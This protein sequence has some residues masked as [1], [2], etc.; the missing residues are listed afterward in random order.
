MFVGDES[1]PSGLGSCGL[2][3]TCVVLEDGA[4]GEGCCPAWARCEGAV[5]EGSGAGLGR[6]TS[7]SA[8]VGASEVAGSWSATAS[9]FL[10]GPAG[11]SASAVSES[12][13]MDSSALMISAPAVSSSSLIQGSAGA[14][15]TNPAIRGSNGAASAYCCSGMFGIFAGGKS[16]MSLCCFDSC[17][18]VE[19]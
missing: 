19:S 7:A 14:R 4:G 6:M 1:C 16:E 9:F 12:Q 18:S 8:S 3:D 2:G 10:M 17:R 11:S 13:V 5:G 15:A